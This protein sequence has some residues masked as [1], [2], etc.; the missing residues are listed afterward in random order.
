MT[1]QGN[2]PDL[3][4][5]DADQTD[6]DYTEERLKLE[7]VVSYILQELREGKKLQ[8]ATAAVQEAADAIQAILEEQDANLASALEQPYFGRVGYLPL[9][10]PRSGSASEDG[11]PEQVHVYIGPAFVPTQ[12]VH[13]W[14]APVARL[15]YT[16]DSGF[17]LSTTT[18]PGRY[19]RVRVDL[20]RFLRIRNQR[21]VSLNDIYRRALPGGAV[22]RS[23]GDGKQDALAAALSES[24]SDGQLSVIIETIEPDQYEA[25]ANT[26]DRVLIVQGAAGSGKSEIGV[27][28][29][30]Y[31]L[32]PFNEMQ[33]RERPTPDTTLFIGPSKSF[34]EY[35]ADLL[36]ILGVQG[37]VEQTTRGEWMQSQR[38][39]NVRFQARVWNNLLAQ[40]GLS[41][42]S[43]Q[44]ESF[45]GSLEMAAL[46]ERHV[47]TRFNSI[48]SQSRLHLLSRSDVTFGDGT[49]LSEDEVGRALD[50]AH[51][52]VSGSHPNP[53]RRSFINSITNLVRS[54]R[55]PSSRL[56]GWEDLQWRRATEQR[57]TDWCDK[58]WPHI[59]VRQE[60]SSLLSN[61]EAILRLARGKLS[62]EDAEAIRTSA[63]RSLDGGFDDSDEG[64]LTYLDQLLNGTIQPKYRHIV[65]DEAQ[66]ISPIEFKLLSISSTNNWFTI[67]GDT[68]QR[69]TPYRGIKR[70][71]EV[72]RV[73]GRD[74]T[75][76]QQAR[77]S[78]RSNKHITRFNNRVLRL[79]ER[80]LPSPI[81]YERDGHRPEYHRHASVDGMYESVI[82]DLTRLRALPGLN[83][84]SIAIL[85]RDRTNLNRFQK[86]C[87]ERGVS[88]IVLVD[89]ERYRAGGTVLARIPDVRGL[90]YDAVIVLGVNETFTSTTFNQRLLYVAI[91][92]AKHYLAI[93]WSGKQSPILSGVYDGGVRFFNRVRTEAGDSGVRRA[94]GERHVSP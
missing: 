18:H 40:G 82:H 76:V 4:S 79:Y 59:D 8:P 88:D 24:G 55:P 29:I 37:R 17:P 80:N 32:S 39:G 86:F 2:L 46:L 90:E 42:F 47:N 72:G 9:D 63:Q 20:K 7:A 19:I 70:W 5:E 34:L 36:P 6:S 67:M 3:S 74:E 65:I 49:S 68:S 94:P 77:L 44:A 57:I 53:R 48:K 83:N 27:H 91:S 13:S 75:T 14:T 58:A 31:L 30:A 52:A 60:Y 22:Q 62:G 81:P 12:H 64:A 69:L 66:D 1:Q 25:I 54:K 78:Y 61:S 10:G 92:R 71:S 85:A 38:S 84:A 45:K 26:S 73:L 93:H 50:A 56:S 28:R 23:L 41:R 51:S 43:E 21:L 16:S 11:Q 35:T 33:E 87:E 15:W 89:Q